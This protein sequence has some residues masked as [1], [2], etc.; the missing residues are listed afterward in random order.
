MPR[1]Q[2]ARRWITRPMRSGSAD[3]GRRS[4]REARA[5]DRLDQAAE[6]VFDCGRRR[7]WPLVHRT[8]PA[9]PATTRSTAM[10]RAGRADADGA[11]LRQ[12]RHRH[13][14]AFT[15]ARTA[16]R[17]RDACRRACADLGVGKGDR[18]ILY[19]P[20]VPEAVVR[21]ARLRAASARCIRWCSAALP[22]RN[23]RPASTTAS[24]S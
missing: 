4:G 12:S 7:L 5:G 22:P 19:M 20:M 18:V 24:R 1:M 14:G 21:H 6:Q 16:R 23:S 11:D 3:L 9:T 17:G 13:Q 8:R 15:Y 2:A 10:S